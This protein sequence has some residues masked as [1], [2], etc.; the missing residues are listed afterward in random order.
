MHNFVNL[1]IKS[2]TQS[3]SY[4]TNEYNFSHMC[5]FFIPNPLSDVLPAGALVK[6][7]GEYLTL[8]KVCLSAGDG[9]ILKW[10]HPVNALRS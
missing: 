7:A 2:A 5:T 1:E 10:R 3:L 4:V 8:L 9:G 6:Y